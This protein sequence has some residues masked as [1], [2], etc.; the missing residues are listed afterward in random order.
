MEEKFMKASQYDLRM[1]IIK[2]DLED[3]LLSDGI[4]CQLLS[5]EEQEILKSY[6]KDP[7]TLKIIRETVKNGEWRNEIQKLVSLIESQISE[8]YNQDSNLQQ[9]IHEYNQELLDSIEN[10]TGRSDVLYK[11]QEKLPERKE[12]ELV[13][14]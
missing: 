13:K 14:I 3:I 7:F 2:R 4:T 8:R 6:D 10:Q 5:Q 11:K 1:L 9:R 12:K